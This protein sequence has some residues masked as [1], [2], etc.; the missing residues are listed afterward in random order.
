[1]NRSPVCADGSPPYSTTQPDASADR[2]QRQ[3]S[4]YVP[5]ARW[6]GKDAV[7]VDE[8]GQSASSCAPARPCPP[9]FL[10]GALRADGGRDSTRPAA[11]IRTK[12]D[13]I[14]ARELPVIIGE[15]DRFGEAVVR[16]PDR[17]CYPISTL[18][19]D[20]QVAD[21]GAVTMRRPG[22]AVRMLTSGTTGRRSGSTSPTTCW[23]TA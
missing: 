23:R 6:P 15:T 22:V 21:G 12:D 4:T 19:D 1:M 3:W 16:I 7:D 9:P 2:I 5:V 13:I 17:P 10:R 11:M 18:D 20:P 14:R 8:R